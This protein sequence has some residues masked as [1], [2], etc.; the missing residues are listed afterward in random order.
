MAGCPTREHLEQFLSGELS[1]PEQDSACAHV[2]ECPAYQ[3]ALEALVTTGEA[4][5]LV[6]LHPAARPRGLHR[7][8]LDKLK[9]TPPGDWFSPRWSASSAVK[10]GSRSRHS[11]VADDSLRPGHIPGYELLEELGRGGMGVVYKARQLAL[12][13]MTAVK[14]LRATE[15]ASL[16]DL[17]RF[18]TEVEAAAA[19][20]HPNIVQ[21]YEVGEHEG[22]PFFSMEYVDG[23]TL[24]QWL[25]GPRSRPP[26]PRPSSNVWPEPSS[27]RTR[28]ASS[29]ATSSRITSCCRG[30][31]GE[32][33]G[34]SGIPL[35]PRPSPLLPKITDF[36]L[37][38]RLDDVQRTQRG[39]LLGTPSYMAP[40]QAA[41]NSRPIAPALDIY[42]LG[43]ILYELLTGRPPFLADSWEA[44]L[45]RVLN[46][47]PVAP[48]HLQPGVPR[49]LEI[50]C[51][52]CL[53]KDPRKRYASA[54][55][56]ADDLHRVLTRQRIT[57][58]APSVW[59]RCQKF[60]RR[61][62]A[63]VG[64]A[65]GVLVALLLGQVSSSLRA[66]LESA[67]SP[68]APSRQRA[69][70]GLP[71]GYQTHLAAAAAALAQ[72]DLAEAAQ[73]LRAAPVAG[74]GWEWHYLHS[75]LDDSLAQVGGFDPGPEAVAFFPAG[76]RVV[77]LKKGQ[78]FLLDA[79]D[80]K[81]QRRYGPAE[82]VFTAWTRSGPLLF[83][84][85]KG[86]AELCLVDESGAVSQRY[87]WN[88]VKEL[89]TPFAVS[90]DGR[91][92]AV[93]DPL[94][95]GQVV[96]YDVASGKVRAELKGHQDFV[97]AL[98]FNP[99]GTR[100]AS[101]SA[102]RSVRLW[103]TMSGAECKVL[104]GH[105][106]TV[107]TVTFSP[108]GKR[109]L[110]GGRDG[111]IRQWDAR[112]GAALDTRRG[113]AQE[114]WCVAYSPDGTRIA[115]AGQGGLRLWATDG[116][117]PLA[118]LHGDQATV[119]R[120][121][122]S[123]DGE[124]I[125]TAAYDGVARVWEPRELNAV[126]VLRGHRSP[127]SPV[128]IS[129]DGRW[130][131][132]AGSD[133]EIRLWDGLTAEPLAVLRGH[134]S[135]VM[136]LAVN[137]AGTRLVSWSADGSLRLWDPV[138]ARLLAS[139]PFAIPWSAEAPHTL[140]V[141]PDGKWLVCASGSR[142]HRWELATLR[143]GQ[144]FPLPA[145]RLHQVAGSPDGLRLALAGEDGAIYQVAA[146]TGQVLAVARGHQ[147]VVHAISHSPDGRLLL[148][149]GEDQ[150]VRLWDA[151]TGEPRRELRGHSSGVLAARFSPDGN[152][153]ASGCRN[154]AICI[155]DTESGAEVARLRGH[156]GHVFALAF[157]A[158][159]ATL[160][161]GSGDTT[162]RV[163]DAFPAAR[164]LQARHELQR[165]QP[166]AE[167]RVRDLLAKGLVPGEVVARVQSTAGLSELQKRAAW[168]AVLRRSQPST[169]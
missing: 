125:A 75:R 1:D 33:R 168:Q 92:L 142:L 84:A 98:A 154:R 61:H 145:P 165:L 7:P 124:R 29:T 101:A 169:P 126:R 60:A 138:S 129:P 146:S 73:H 15:P 44:T 47:E 4:P 31:R 114:V 87:R 24:R 93:A 121:A 35:F 88:G 77:A 109:I 41:G 149:A 113:Q 105:T 127:V 38:K 150:T 14:M 94:V 120:L 72:H 37:A 58:R 99:D 85:G 140:G 157:S 64:A 74:R 46:E 152:R 164:R 71:E 57:A 112:T 10:A 53:E 111:T 153:I 34:A 116:G 39:R 100:L 17:G 5:R 86:R 51:L 27:T 155:W 12:G 151:T 32:G 70:G 82:A 13:R 20:Q 162:V 16:E 135:R 163:W 67:P 25:R 18:R 42:S 117:E 141:S 81:E 28:A 26:R 78:A 49:D 167:R 115:S 122:F 6:A 54:G 55:D 106:N 69:P 40:E 22:R 89:K 96:I 66:P 11:D 130:F 76:R 19:L 119:A 144:G 36:G 50:V 8:F 136:A 2:E 48:R 131:A 160:V 59:S 90:E 80:G 118:V 45:L 137:R 107:L 56:L 110:S 128:A 156:T 63:L 62:K 166:E 30:T 91:Q 97:Y 161:S 148:S 65:A 103:N 123:P 139:V 134:T 3:G 158:D 159:G 143:A 147:G 21:V 132:S 9:N 95:H 68:A 133:R 79:L 102:D 83:L 23:G 52:K 43:A 108:D 104:H